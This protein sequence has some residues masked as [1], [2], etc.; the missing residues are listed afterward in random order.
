MLKPSKP[1]HRP[2]SK[3][4]PARSPVSPRF[5][6]APSFATGE[7]RSAG[8]GKRAEGIR[9]ERKV[10]SHLLDLYGEFYVP[11]PWLQFYDPDQRICQPDGLLFDFENGVITL[12]EIKLRHCTDAYWQL[13]KLYQPVLRCMFP[14]SI[15]DIRCIEVVRW[16]DPCV[17]WPER[18][19]MRENVCDSVRGVIG[20][21]IYNP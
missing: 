19:I 9:Y 10:Q 7:A 20:V 21:H 13:R 6:D 11:G 17:V 16:Y 1:K 15:W 3:F 18:H 12:V 4:K 14:A 5:C 8:R 2:P